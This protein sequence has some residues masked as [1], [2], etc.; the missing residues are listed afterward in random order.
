VLGKHR[1]IYFPETSRSGLPYPGQS[2]PCSQR[3]PKCLVHFLEKKKEKVHSTTLIYRCNMS[4]NPQPQNQV[5]N[6]HK[7]SKPSNLHPSAVF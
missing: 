5:F 4:C 3:G 7:L 1:G 6:T 2:C